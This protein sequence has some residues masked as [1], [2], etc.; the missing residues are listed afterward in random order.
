MGRQKDNYDSLNKD[1]SYFDTK[2]NN[3]KN[4]NN[5]LKLNLNIID[6]YKT[7]SKYLIY[8][9]PLVLII[10]ICILIYLIYITY[11]KFM[12]NVYSQY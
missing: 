9:Y 12:Q 10:C 6:G 5:S 11:Q 7:Q 8:I 4:L 1:E 2:K 3:Y